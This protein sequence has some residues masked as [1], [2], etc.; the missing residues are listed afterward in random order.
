MKKFF[1][2]FI[3]ILLFPLTAFAIESE[4]SI[5][6]LFSNSSPSR[7]TDN[8]I[9]TTISFS[10]DEHIYINCV[11]YSAIMLK[12]NEPA[13]YNIKYLNADGESIGFDTINNNIL[14]QY[15]KLQNAAKL[16]IH[17]PLGGIL[18]DV[19]V[20]KDDE[21]D[22][23]TQVWK[24]PY[25]KADILVISAHADDEY[26]YMGGTIPYYGT[27]RG[28]KVAVVWMSHQKRL[29][30][31]EALAA[32]WAMK[33]E[34]YPEFLGFPDRLSK[35]YRDG[36]KVWGGEEKVLGSIVELYRKY[37]P[38]VVVTHDL[39]GE[40]GHGAHMITAAMALEAA[41]VAFDETQFVESVQEYGTWQIKKLY[42]HLFH[43]NKI[44]M[45]W[46]QPLEAFGGN[47]ALDMAKIG[48]SYHKSQ[49]I[50]NFRVSDTSKNSC[51]KFGLAFSTVGI[52][53]EKDDF[54]ENIPDTS[55]SNYALPELD[56]IIDAPTIEPNY[57]KRELASMPEQEWMP[58]H[59]DE[60]VKQIS[61]EPNDMYIILILA[62]TIILVT[63]VILILL[64]LKRKS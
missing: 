42:L 4:F 25:D 6:F 43:E 9:S 22:K 3:I 31:D 48:Y 57:D 49:H 56:T 61:S 44:T 58:A 30:Q 50:W 1:L 62:G 11:G 34:H 53:V 46:N 41:T 64:L 27:E 23:E 13:Q 39:K 55:L 20:Y 10:Q 45:D 33:V 35:T 28:L 14:N 37:K 24:E 51:A 38:E 5:S 52:D 21:E 36:A 63:V 18:C 54:L 8:K 12:W 26:L 2:V 32:L 7:L 16:D 15:I 19:I 29:R 59:S 60:S 40:Y 47:T 17:L